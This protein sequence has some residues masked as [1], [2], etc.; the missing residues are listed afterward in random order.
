MDF[1]LLAFL[2]ICLYFVLTRVEDDAGEPAQGIGLRA[3]SPNR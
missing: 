3:N 2:A 1:A